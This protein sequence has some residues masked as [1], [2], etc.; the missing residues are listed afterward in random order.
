[1]STQTTEDRTYLLQLL[2]PEDYARLRNAFSGQISPEVQA[3][4]D[5]IVN[6]SDAELEQF[7]AVTR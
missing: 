6:A 5:A 1:M 2:G 4:L 3:R 7:A